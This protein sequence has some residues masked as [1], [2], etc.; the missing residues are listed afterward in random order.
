AKL[1][2]PFNQRVLEEDKPLG[3]QGFFYGLGPRLS[4]RL[5]L[6]PSLASGLSCTNPAKRCLHR[7]W[8]IACQSPTLQPTL[9][10]FP[11]VDDVGNVG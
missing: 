2:I 11:L 4:L 7:S 1:E 10:P 9:P 8:V 5:M 6:K 3:N